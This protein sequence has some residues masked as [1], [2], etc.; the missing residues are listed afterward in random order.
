M[1]SKQKPKKA[2]VTMRIG[3]TTMLINLTSTARTRRIKMIGLRMMRHPS[4]HWTI[5]AA[6]T[7]A[8]TRWQRRFFQKRGFVVGVT[9][10]MA[11]NM[12]VERW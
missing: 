12:F 11:R 8:T 4:K 7:R 10:R 3:L 2:T 1:V 5:A 9:L 6:S